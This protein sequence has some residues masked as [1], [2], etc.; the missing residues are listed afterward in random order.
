MIYRVI[1]LT[2][3]AFQNLMA[4][5]WLNVLT[6]LVIALSLTLVG[7]FLMA[8]NNASNLVEYFSGQVEVMIYLNDDHTKLEA[9]ALVGA[10]Q[11]RPMVESATFITKADA[12]ARF[13]QEL[14]ELAEVVDSMEGNPLPASIEVK[15]APGF[16]Q[17]DQLEAL[18]GSLN[19]KPGVEEVYYGKEWIEKM[20]RAVSVFWIF[21]VSVGIFL[22]ST[23]VFIISTTLKLAIHRRQEEIGVMRLV[24]ATN[25]YIQAPFI[26]EGLLQ[27]LLGASLSIGA[28]F[29][30]FWF[31]IS[32][33]ADS[34]QVLI[35]LFPGFT[36]DFLPGY[37][38]GALLIMGVAVGLFGSLF[39]IGKFLKV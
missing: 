28:L 19:G 24:G 5:F 39:S 9:D 2:K 8:A 22:S 1:L 16:R 6:I 7:A 32:K 3:K 11:K 21:G 36:I 29:G 10:L 14:A 13:K 17:I 12:L 34:N 18:A 30:V 25:K 33:F 26:I 15:I 23:A 37:G 35:P 20:A 27:G 31:F 38:L 4:D